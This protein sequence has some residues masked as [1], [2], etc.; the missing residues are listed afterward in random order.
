M[1]SS[2]FETLEDVIREEL[3]TYRDIL[4]ISDI[5][6]VEPKI[7]FSKPR[8]DFP[9][10]ILNL[11]KGEKVIFQRGVSWRFQKIGESNPMG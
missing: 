4:E 2:T 10:D 3:S 11:K 5:L 6:K 7:N 9:T 8:K 1:Y